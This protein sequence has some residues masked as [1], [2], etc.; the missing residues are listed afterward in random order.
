MKRLSVG[1]TAAALLASSLIV[2]QGAQWSA[3]GSGE[4]R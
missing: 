1:G 3:A 2:V 4:R